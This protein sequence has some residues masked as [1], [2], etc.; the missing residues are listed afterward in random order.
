MLHRAVA[1]HARRMRYQKSRKKSRSKSGSNK[2][3]VEKNLVSPIPPQ[4]RRPLKQ[5]VRLRRRARDVLQ[6]AARRC[7]GIRQQYKFRAGGGGDA[8]PVVRDQQRGR[9]RRQELA[10][11]RHP[12][13]ELLQWENS[14]PL[15]NPP[16]ICGQ[17]Q[18]R[19]KPPDEPRSPARRLRQAAHAAPV[20]AIRRAVR[21]ADGGLRVHGQ[22][23]VFVC[24]KWRS[25]SPLL[26]PRMSPGARPLSMNPKPT[27]D[28]TPC[29]APCRWWASGSWTTYQNSEF[30]SSTSMELYN[31]SSHGLENFW[32]MTESQ[33]LVASLR[34]K[35]FHLRVCGFFR[36]L[37]RVLPAKELR[38][39][40]R[41]S[42][43]GV[44]AECSA[45]YR[46]TSIRVTS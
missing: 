4:L 35:L 30:W 31:T 17:L 29:S 36:V 3:S 11:G 24:S 13:G 37:H 28:N 10:G 16:G 8:A 15:A 39:L 12:Q 20:Q 43:V 21:R 2:D 9:N 19:D 27:I 7:R 44:I 33:V 6:S 32:N 5:R 14:P 41:R 42:V 38:E 34:V 1:N 25:T 22:R 18:Q 40:A 46:N 45:R 26:F 23:T